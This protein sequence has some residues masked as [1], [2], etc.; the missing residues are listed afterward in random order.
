MPCV[1]TKSK[2]RRLFSVE[3]MMKGY[4]TY[5]DSWPLFFAKNCQV[6]QVSENFFSVYEGAN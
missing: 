6:F 3:V 2:Q 1:S 4:K 5:K